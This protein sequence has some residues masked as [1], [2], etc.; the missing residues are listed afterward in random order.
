[1]VLKDSQIKEFN[2]PIYLLAKDPCESTYIDN[3]TIFAEMIRETGKGELIFSE[4][5]K[6]FLDDSKIL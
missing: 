2:D 5:K 1:M 6:K 3:K 4:C